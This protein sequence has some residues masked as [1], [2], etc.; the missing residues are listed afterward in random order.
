MLFQG[1]KTCSIRSDNIAKLF[2]LK[3]IFKWNVLLQMYLVFPKNWIIT[4]NSYPR[5]MLNIYIEAQVISGNFEAISFIAYLTVC[6]SHNYVI[7]KTLTDASAAV[8]G[9]RE[10][11]HCLQQWTTQGDFQLNTRFRIVHIWNW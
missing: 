11:K 4:R 2:L 8:C 1:V 6:F 5:D 3:S 7:V 10:A 9:R